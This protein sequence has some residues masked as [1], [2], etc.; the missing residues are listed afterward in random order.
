MRAS[1]AGGTRG[2]SC[3]SMMH[4]FRGSRVGAV[5]LHGAVRFLSYQSV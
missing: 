4:L 3:H 2:M 1:D 5:K